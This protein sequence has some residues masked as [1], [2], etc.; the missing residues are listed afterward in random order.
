MKIK[1]LELKSYTE[2]VKVYRSGKRETKCG[3]FMSEGD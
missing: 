2:P 1:K 3:Y